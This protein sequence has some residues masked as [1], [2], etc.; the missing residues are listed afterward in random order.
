MTEKYIDS[1][2]NELSDKLRTL[3]GSYSQFAEKCEKSEVISNEIQE[4]TGFLQGFKGFKQKFMESLSIVDKNK[5]VLAKSI[6]KLRAYGQ[7]SGIKKVLEEFETVFEGLEKVESSLFTIDNDMLG[8]ERS[9]KLKIQKDSELI[10]RLESQIKKLKR[11][12]SLD[13]WQESPVLTSRN[14]ELPNQYHE[15]LEFRSIIEKMTGETDRINYSSTLFSDG[16]NKVYIDSKE[17][18]NKKILSSLE[19]EI[20]KLRNSV[21]VLEEKE[22]HHIEYRSKYE[23][24]QYELMEFMNKVEGLERIMLEKDLKIDQLLKGIEESQQERKKNSEF[25]KKFKEGSERKNEEQEMIIKKI[26]ERKTEQKLLIQNLN[27]QL[28]IKKQETQEALKENRRIKNSLDYCMSQMK[29]LESKYKQKID[30]VEKDSELSQQLLRSEEE[31]NKALEDLAQVICQVKLKSAECESLEN[32]LKSS[33][34]ELEKTK[35]GLNSLLLEYETLK[36]SSISNEIT[37]SLQLK[38]EETQS[39]SQEYYSQLSSLQSSCDTMNQT[40]TLLNK[41]LSDK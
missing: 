16:C 26:R 35:S 18:T 11:A 5:K 1:L 3:Q 37:D 19:S 25:L 13:N 38:L 14:L 12:Q 23:S 32:S 30:Q 21:R 24:C 15:E 2:M 8:L 17:F 40:L 29:D 6:G 10:Q 27:S 39:L 20:R 9:L 36:S 33:K 4:S 22:I 7:G 34:S 31:K 41:K 28:E